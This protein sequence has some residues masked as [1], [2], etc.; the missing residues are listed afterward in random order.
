MAMDPQK[1]D[2]IF[3]NP[4]MNTLHFGRHISTVS[5]N[6]KIYSAMQMGK[7]KT[8]S[9]LICVT[10]ENGEKSFINGPDGIIHHPSL[11]EDKDGLYTVWNEYAEDS[12]QIKF[13]TVDTAQNSIDNIETVYSSAD[14]CHPPVMAF[15]EDRPYIAFTSLKDS[16]LD[17]YAAV[18]KGD[19]WEVDTPFKNPGIDRF[20]PKLSSNENGI[21]IVWDQYKDNKYEVVFA[22]LKSD[23]WN[24]VEA[25]G[26]KGQRWMTP[27]V[28]AAKDTVYICWVVLEAVIDK[29]GIID[30]HPYI[31][32]GVYKD[33][34]LTDLT[35]DANTQNRY[36]IGDLREGLLAGEIYKGHVGLRR[37]P[38]FTLDQDQN[39]YLFWEMRKETKGSDVYGHLIGRKMEATDSWSKPA[40]YSSSGYS[41]H[42]ANT[43]LSSKLPVSYYFFETKDMDVV[44]SEYVDIAQSKELNIPADKFDRWK[45]TTLKPQQKPKDTVKLDDNKYKLVWADTHCHSNFSADAEGEP[46]ELANFAKDTAGIDI[47]TVIDNDYYP[48]K[49]LT[50]A[51]W[52][53]HGEMSAHFTKKSKFAWLP[54]YE[55]TYHRTDLSPDFNHRCV[56]YPRKGGKLLRR[57]DP[58]SNTDAKM[59]AELKK[60][61]GMAYPHHCSYEL[62]DQDVEWNI[63]ACSSW[64]VCLEET[65]C[66]VEKLKA[67][68][69]LG[70][71]GSSD[72]HRMIPGLASARTGLYVTELTPEAIFD[73]Y[74]NRRIIATQGF[75]IFIDFRVND[76]FI[77]QQT[78]AASSNIIKADIKAYEKIDYVEVFRDGK[79]IWWDS[80]ASEKFSFEFEDKN[81]GQGEHFYFMKVKL[82]G[83]PSLNVDAIP[84]E[85]FPKPFEQNSRYPHNL[86]RGQGVF[87]WTSPVWTNK[88]L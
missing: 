61:N 48:H 16:N 4:D 55:F 8:T 42:I 65:T 7:G 27:R 45:Y 30:Y 37:N 51:E 76:A 84:S 85:N 71:I 57:I 67:G 56:I 80:P 81:A 54:G 44:R 69:K 60:T 10:D 12:W 19:S 38:Q 82:F 77:G 83:D 74:R 14:M 1:K 3:R 68:A 59:I 40:L 79:S 31:R 46:D 21:Y 6:D 66:T 58:D 2:D 86:A 39:L 62:I 15:Y 63:E 64:R 78:K 11:C 88:V 47:I 72:T 23:K 13:A 18:K 43:I 87:A 35:D 24:I 26:R 28:I 70:F 33:G 32:G 49:A 73:A 17:I 9:V 52:L 36:N 75:N 20:R 29:L 53:M 22:E 41:Y 25:L 34:K 5:Y 50:Q